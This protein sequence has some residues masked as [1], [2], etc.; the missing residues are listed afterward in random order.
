MA[1]ATKRLTRSTVGTRGGRKD[2]FCL[3]VREAS[4]KFDLGLKDEQAL[5]VRRGE[6]TA[7]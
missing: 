3:R 6:G 7:F 4:R 2:D 1:S 5:P